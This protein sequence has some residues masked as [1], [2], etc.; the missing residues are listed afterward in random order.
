MKSLT[1]SRKCYNVF[2]TGGLK[3][4]KDTLSLV[5]SEQE[6]Q[7]LTIIKISLYTEKYINLMNLLTGLDMYQCVD[8]LV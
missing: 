4:Q 1:K 5:L 2:I 8:D 3:V 6:K 7:S